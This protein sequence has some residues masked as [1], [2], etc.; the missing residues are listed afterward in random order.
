MWDR[1]LDGSAFYHQIVNELGRRRNEVGQPEV[2][3]NAM[4]SNCVLQ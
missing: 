2:N 1:S 3:V 4:A